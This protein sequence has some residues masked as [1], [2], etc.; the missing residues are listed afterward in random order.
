MSR[1]ANLKSATSLH[2]LGH[3]LGYT[4]KGIAFIL[5]GVPD[6]AKYSEF[7]IKKRSGGI[8]TISA[9]I[10][11]LKRLQQH[12]ASLL[13]ECIG[14][15]DAHRG[16]VNT[17]SHGFRPKHSIM[18][19]AAMHRKHRY[20][21][22]LD[23]KDF[24]DTINFGRVW[25]FFEK[26]REFGLNAT[27][28]RTIAQIACHK[29]TLPQG[30]PCSPVI[31][32]LITHILDIAM[33][34]LAA[35]AKCHYS[36]YADDLTF[37]TN[38]SEFPRL[39]ATRIGATTQ[40]EV[41]PKV[42]REIVRCGFQVNPLKTRMQYENSRQDVT[43]IV[44]NSKVNVRSEYSRDV[45]AKVSSLLTNNAFYV[46]KTFR[47]DSGS[48]EVETTDGKDAQ[49]RGMLSFIDS[50]RL[51]ERRRN[52]QIPP[53]VHIPRLELKEMDGSSCIYRAFLL[54]TQFYRPAR[55]L[56]ICEGKTDNVYIRCALHSLAAAH[57]KLIKTSGKSLECLIDFF[58]YSKTS[59]RILHL[60]GG[61]GDLGNF[62]ANYASEFSRF[63]KID[64]RNPVII[65]I[66]NDSGSNQIFSIIKKVTKSTVNID[67]SSTFYSI[68]DN[69]Y[70]VPIPKIGGRETT[71]EHFFTKK[72]LATK[73][74]GKVFSGTDK[75]DAATQYGKHLFSEHVIKK[76]KDK[77]SF[78]KFGFILKNIEAALK[79]H[80]GKP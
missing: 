65:L 23:L 53:D 5:H 12:L 64:A 59:D 20:V 36:R 29:G 31:S 72:V 15:S 18:T 1:L 32:N 3:I 47:N 35:K 2:D 44:V 38:E 16:V 41:A 24:F 68:K 69:L 13:N 78:S 21:F 45:R 66:D 70:V 42:V 40:W 74:N 46:N 71:I 7:T 51:F 54:F 28:A 19:N 37:S 39:I 4:A 22:N 14:E 6:A 25:K 27:T 73:L 62:I 63:K 30:S 49:L 58:S 26:N 8:R 80:Y 79:F 77:I 57:P 67:G 10:P 34:Q 60:A 52:E 33:V 11:E 76:N 55:P 50:V 75:F 17:L 48:W 61:T 43:G 56:I 9:P